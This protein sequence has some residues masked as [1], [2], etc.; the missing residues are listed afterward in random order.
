[1]PD[2]HKLLDSVASQWVKDQ[3]AVS[4]QNGGI[5]DRDRVEAL[6]TELG[7]LL[8]KQTEVVESRTLG[9]A[10]DTEILEYEIRQEIIREMSNQLANSE[11]TA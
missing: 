9:A 2:T 5:M 4:P 11:T 7:Q 6:R 10:T 3:G 1:M 8:R